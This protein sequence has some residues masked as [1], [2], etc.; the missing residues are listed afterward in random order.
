MATPNRERQKRWQEKQA[1]AGRKRFTVV[2]ERDVYEILTEHKARTGETLSA[3][4]NRAVRLLPVA[5]CEPTGPPETPPP[6]DTPG[7]E[8]GIDEARSMI[9]RLL[10]LGRR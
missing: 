9:R 6:G 7:A 10:T 1:A 5:P 4:I 3:V 2:V 8:R